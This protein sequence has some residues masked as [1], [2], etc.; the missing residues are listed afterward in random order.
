[1]KRFLAL[2]NGLLR[3]TFAILSCCGVWIVI[4]LCC[5]SQIAEL[6]IRL[7]AQYWCPNKPESAEV[8]V[9]DPL[10][11]ITIASPLL[12]LI[13]AQNAIQLEAIIDVEPLERFPLWRLGFHIMPHPSYNYHIFVWNPPSMP[14]VIYIC[15]NN[16][17]PLKTLIQDETA[18][19]IYSPDYELFAVYETRFGNITLF[20]A[21]TLKALITIDVHDYGIYN[22][23]PTYTLVRSI[24]FH[25]TE[26]I[27]AF[28]RVVP[29]NPFEL[30][31]WNIETNRQIGAF[32]FTEI[33][34]SSLTFN[35]DG[36][37]LYFHDGAG[38][39]VWGVPADN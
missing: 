26:P 1:M 28:T 20:D 31:L 18:Q 32:E 37:L 23:Y 21:E 6:S 39:H 30:Y 36:T 11:E 16:N 33:G 15:D 22:G 34:D 25:P 13:T 17:K 3:L 9:Q 4:G 35:T 14:A 19:V 5:G 27:L 29:G 2:L 12:E 10:P 7:G 24:A 8:F 38:G